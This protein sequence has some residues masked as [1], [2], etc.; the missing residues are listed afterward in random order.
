MGKSLSHTAPPFLFVVVPQAELPDLLDALDG[1]STASVP[2]G[3]LR[4]MEDVNSKGGAVHLREVRHRLG[5]SRRGGAQRPCVMRV[6]WGT[7]S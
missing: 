3:L 5:V 4:D 6:C 1:V 7:T 2:E